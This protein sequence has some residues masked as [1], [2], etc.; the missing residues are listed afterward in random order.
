MHKLEADW[1]RSPGKQ[2]FA[3]FKKALQELAGPGR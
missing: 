2:R 1:Q 3:D